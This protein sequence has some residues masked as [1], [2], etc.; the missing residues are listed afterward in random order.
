MA[1]EGFLVLGFI[2]LS[3]LVELPYWAIVAMILALVAW[4][5]VIRWNWH[6][7]PGDAYEQQLA[8]ASHGVAFF[9]L[10]PFLTFV[11]QKEHLT[12]WL[13]PSW[14]PWLWPATL[15]FM[16]LG[17]YWLVFGWVRTQARTR[18]ARLIT[19]SLVKVGIGAVVLFFAL[20]HTIDLSHIDMPYRFYARLAAVFFGAWHCITGAVKLILLL[21]PPKT[22]G[23]LPRESRFMAGWKW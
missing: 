21:R 13:P 8:K 22:F 20:T 15:A 10:A 14:V 12:Y 23:P 4:E 6:F 19:R 5:V 3:F 9:L 2:A 17:I 11:T 16:G 18:D 1:T 7:K